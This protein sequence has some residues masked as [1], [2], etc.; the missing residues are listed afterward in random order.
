M[1]RPVVYLSGD[2]PKSRRSDLFSLLRVGYF[3][4]LR[5]FEF[6]GEGVSKVYID[7]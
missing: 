5:A 3:R 2:F 6:N 7:R 4:L 1:R